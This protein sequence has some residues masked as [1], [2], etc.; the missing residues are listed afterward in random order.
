[1]V[2]VEFVNPDMAPDVSGRLPPYGEFARKVQRECFK[3]KLI[4][5]I[6]GRDG[7]VVRFLPPLTISFE[8]IDVA[9]DRFAAA[10]QAVASA[11]LYDI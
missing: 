9:V 10:V 3:R 1:M 11:T 4:C 2:G 7:S 5:E 8:E 6:G